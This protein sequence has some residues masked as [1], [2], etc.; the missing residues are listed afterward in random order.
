[1]KDRFWPVLLMLACVAA[2]LLAPTLHGEYRP[3]RAEPAC[4]VTH[5]PTACGVESIPLH[6]AHDCQACPLCRVAQESGLSGLLIWRAWELGVE[7]APMA[8]TSCRDP[9]GTPR[10]LTD[11]PPRGPPTLF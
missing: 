10:V 8:A 7:Q 11:S 4:S 3:A 6:A 5:M 2:H 1:M 9:G